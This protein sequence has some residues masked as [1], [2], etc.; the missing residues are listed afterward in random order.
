[1]K[2]HFLELETMV[3]NIFSRNPIIYDRN[4][5]SKAY[6]LLKG[7]KKNLKAIASIYMIKI[8]T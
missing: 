2:V 1:M 8:D 6:F 4:C 3:K 7:K 5:R